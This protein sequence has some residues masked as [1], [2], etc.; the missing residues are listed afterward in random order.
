METSISIGKNDISPLITYVEN[1][2]DSFTKRPLCAIDALVLAQVSYLRLDCMVGD[3]AHDHIP[4]RSLLKS[5][6]FEYL[7]EDT[8]A[9]ENSLLLLYAVCASP[10]FRDVKMGF[11]VNVVSKESEE[12]F[13]A[14]T[15]VL[16]TDECVIGFRGTDSTMIGWKEDLNM[17]FLF[18]IPSQ[19]EAL[20]YV[21]EVADVVNMPI[22]IT[23]HSKGGNLA[24]YGYSFASL[25][26][27]QRVVNVYN[28]D[29]PGFPQDIVQGEQY[30]Q[31]AEKIIKFMPEASIIGLFLESTTGVNFIKSTGFSLLS[32]DLF[33]WQIE[34]AQFV[35][36]EKLTRNMQRADKK[37]N[38]WV[39]ELDLE[40]RQIFVGAMFSIVYALD[41]KSSDQLAPA[42]IKNRKKVLEI[43][44]DMDIDTATCVKES[45]K[46][47]VGISSF[48]SRSPKEQLDKFAS[49]FSQ[50]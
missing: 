35:K 16:P 34:G 6:F 15:F 23:G 21:N 47:L 4:I 30:K 40:Q 50:E 29:G 13:S 39:Y 8:F 17:T 22:Y 7:C 45:L 41:V 37:I 26:I 42:L 48:A 20:K 5:E 1:H 36:G 14:T 12:Q 10:R 11:H 43:L 24:A 28:F 49:M 38:Q 2:K 44:H 3:F 9:P 46:C 19:T 25:E 33:T 32:H 18:P 31:G 27:K